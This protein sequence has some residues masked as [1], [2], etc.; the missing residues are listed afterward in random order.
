MIFYNSVPSDNLEAGKDWDNGLAVLG[1]AGLVHEKDVNPGHSQEQVL[2][3]G[4]VVVA[5]A[6]QNYKYRKQWCESVSGFSFL[7]QCGSVR[8]RILILV[9]LQSHKIFIFT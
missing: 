7:S 9:R 5:P 2:Y 6:Q 8:I 4:K 3:Y 1:E